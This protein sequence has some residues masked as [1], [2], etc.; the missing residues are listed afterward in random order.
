MSCF[1]NQFE[2]KLPEVKTT[3]FTTMS[4]L[5]VE[6]N[7]L[8]LSQGFPDFDCPKILLEETKNALSKNYNQYAPMAGAE[9]LRSAI[10]EKIKDCY[11]TDY[12]ADTEIT[13]TAG[14]TQALYTAISAFVNPGDE[15]IVIKP[16]YDSYE[17]AI[18]INGG[19]PIHYQLE[20]PNYKIDW[21]LFAQKISTKTKMVVVNTPHNPTGTILDK[22]DLLALERVLKDT[23]ILLLSDEV[24]EHILFDNEIHQ[25]ACLFPELK[26]R[27][28]ICSSF[29]KTYHITGWKIGYC[30]APKELMTEFRKVHQY[31]VFSVNHPA[32]IGLAN[33]LNKSNDYLELN[34][35]YQEKRDFFLDAIKDSR[36]IYTPS[37][38]TYFQLLDYSNI[39]NENDLE[40]AIRLVK[41]YKVAAIPFSPFNTKN[42]DSKVLRFCFA[43]K[44]VT[45]EKAAEILCKIN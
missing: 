31:N 4:K 29:G 14:A 12:C 38:G 44:N 18:K 9:L 16:A 24:Y 26:K 40:Y 11:H 41:E 3:I 22:N 42:T 23:S 8:N 13:V 1:Y 32:Q 30:V 25:S 7:A 28:I 35:F 36:F 17:P 20:G 21:E 43:K 37:K 33:H 10:S 27:A 39:T 6:N 45:L 2:S 19:I 5:A 34:T 15:V